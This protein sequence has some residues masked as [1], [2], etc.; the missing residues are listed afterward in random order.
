LLSAAGAFRQPAGEGRM[1]ERK[2]ERRVRLS[3]YIDVPVDR[4]DAV[5]VALQRHIDLTRAE[6]GCLAFN[7]TQCGEVPGRFLVSEEFASQADFDAHQ[8][9]TRNSEWSSLSQGLSRNYEFE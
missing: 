5:Q 7:V 6:P 9:R 3:G 2:D 1:P 4:L 8:A